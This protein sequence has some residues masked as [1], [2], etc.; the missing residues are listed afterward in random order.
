MD[1]GLIDVGT[2]MPSSIDGYK[3]CALLFSEEKRDFHFSVLNKAKKWEEKFINEPIIVSDSLPERDGYIFDRYLLI[4]KAL[5]KCD[6]NP[7]AQSSYIIK[8]TVNKSGFKIINDAPRDEDNRVVVLH[9][10]G[11]EYGVFLDPTNPCIVPLPDLP[12]CTV[13]HIRPF[14]GI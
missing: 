5:E 14:V 4:P 10:G 1:D 13:N 3:I 7:Q 2:C 9:E 8:P 11:N 6:P 12:A